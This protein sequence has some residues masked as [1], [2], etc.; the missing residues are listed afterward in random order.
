MRLDKYLKVSRLIKRRE[1]A[2]EF[3][4]QGYVKLNDK[5]CKPSSEV[6][7]GDII[8]ITTV[9]QT[10]IKAKVLQVRNSSTIANASLMFQLITD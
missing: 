7:E 5:D 8:E 6:K 2:K 4:L 9:K 10:K 3:V 1:L